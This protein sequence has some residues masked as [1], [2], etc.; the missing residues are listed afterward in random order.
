MDFI[1]EK[2]GARRIRPIGLGDD[3]AS[4]EDDFVEWKKNM[5]SPLIEYRTNNPMGAEDTFMQD[6][7]QKPRKMSSHSQHDK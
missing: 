5:W 1:L 2:L 3:N 4:L 7:E 6:E